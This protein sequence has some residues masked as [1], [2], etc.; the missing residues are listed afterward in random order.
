MVCRVSCT[1]KW[2]VD[3][4]PTTPSI[5]ISPPI[6]STSCLQI[7]RPRPV[8]PKLRVVEPSACMNGSKMALRRSSGMPMPVSHTENRRCRGPSPRSPVARSPALPPVARSPALPPVTRSPALPPVARS[9]APRPASASS[10]DG[11]LDPGAANSTR[12]TTSPRSVNLMALPA[13]LTRIWRRRPGS[14]RT[15][16]G[17][18]GAITELSAMLFS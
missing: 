10:V 7:A 16:A 2:K 14:P 5:P 13:R 9:P 6:F 17:T 8:P 18:S 4:S 11:A 15:A 3:P 12:M 1:V